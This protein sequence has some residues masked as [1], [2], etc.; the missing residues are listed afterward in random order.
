[1]DDQEKQQLYQRLANVEK[2]LS[3]LHPSGLTKKSYWARV[4]TVFG[5]SIV[6]YLLWTSAAILL[7]AVMGLFGYIGSLIQ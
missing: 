3:E 2:Q 4:L 1:M 7:F 6:L 5:Y